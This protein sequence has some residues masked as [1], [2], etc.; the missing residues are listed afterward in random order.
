MATKAACYRLVALV[1]VLCISGCVQLTEEQQRAALLSELDG[2]L[3]Q[4]QVN[5]RQLERRMD[6][7]TEDRSCQ[8]DQQCRVL[9]KGVRPCGGPEQ[10]LAYSVLSTDESMLLHT[11]EQFS[12]LRQRQHERLGTISSCELLPEP[13]PS[14]QQNLC[15]LQAQEYASR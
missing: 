2:S 12:S 8:Q 3:A 6:R 10:Y 11:N 7:L 4:L 13:L 9:A 15:T 14:C 5:L 1:T